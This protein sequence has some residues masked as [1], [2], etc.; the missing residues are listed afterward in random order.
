[1]DRGYTAIWLMSLYLIGGIIRKKNLLEKF[2]SKVYFVG[3][4]ACVLLAWGSKVLIE[5]ICF[6]LTGEIAGGGL[7]ISYISPIM[8]LQAICLLGMFVK[9]HITNKIINKVIC[10]IARTTFSVFII[11]NHPLMQRQFLKGSFIGYGEET[12]IIMVL[13]VLGTALVFF[14]VCSVIDLVRMQIFRVF[15][16]ND[17]CEVFCQRIGKNVRNVLKKAKNVVRHK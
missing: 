17:Y 16:V 1:M 5:S 10:T 4:W 2:S 13:K 6:R 11:H 12:A 7:L 14:A 9:V 3:F 15:H 8:I